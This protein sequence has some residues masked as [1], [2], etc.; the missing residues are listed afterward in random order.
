MAAPVPVVYDAGA[1]VAAE[2]D[3]PHFRALHTR[4][5]RQDRRILVP[6]PVLAQVWRA[7]ARQVRLVWTLRGCVVE[8]TT[9][10]LAR[11]AGALL[12]RSKT[13]DAVDAIVVASAVPRRALIVTGDPDDLD[14]LWGAAEVGGPAPILAV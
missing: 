7:G 4:F 3:D 14:L 12:G 10:E 8:P 9:E 5:V 2:R 1:L 13:T 6:A 11:S